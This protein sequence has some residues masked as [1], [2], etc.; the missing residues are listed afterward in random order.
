M[1]SLYKILKENVLVEGRKEDVMAKYPDVDKKVIEQLS[2]SDPSGN[3]KYLEFMVKQ[4]STSSVST[5]VQVVTMYHQKQA[6]INKRTVEEFFSSHTIGNQAVVL[7]A[8][9]DINSF[10][11]LTDL[12]EFVTFLNGIISKRKEL[13]EIKKGADVIYEDKDLL[14]VSPQTHKSSCHY[15]LHSTWCVA[16]E[17]P[18]HY[19]SYT[20]DAVLYFFI[21]K[22]DKAYNKWWAEATTPRSGNPGQPANTPPFKTALLLKDGGIA[23]WWSKNDNNYASGSVSGSGNGWVGDPLLPMLTQE[24]ADRILSHNR[25]LVKNRKQKEIDKIAKSAGFYKRNGGDS[26]MRTDFTTFVRL[27]TYTPEQLVKI[28]R[29][30]NWLAFYENSDTGK[31]IRKMLTPNVIFSLLREYLTIDDDLKETLKDMHHQSF[32]ETINDILSDEQNQEIAKT[33]VNRLGGELNVKEV[34][35]DARLYVGRWTMTPEEKAKYE[36]Q[37]YYFYNGTIKTNKDGVQL[38]VFTELVKV[39]K[40]NPRDHRKLSALMQKGRWARENKSEST[41]YI[42]TAGKGEFDEYIRKDDVGMSSKDIPVPVLK[43]IMSLSKKVQ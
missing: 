9:K 27:G 16:A 5:I 6:L 33:I 4:L 31:V 10:A 17:G 38:P 42:V 30:D 35:N 15:G 40:F 7:K 24:I 32:F 12:N 23:E 36:S 11:S 19:N 8:P 41:V 13:E 43:K 18:T 26:Q 29:N 34:G 37:T 2:Q 22:T 20:K 21:S 25:E 14:V 28:I 39:D 1:T 3:N